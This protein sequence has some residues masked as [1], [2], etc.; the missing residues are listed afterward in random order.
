MKAGYAEPSP[1]SRQKARIS[2]ETQFEGF[3]TARLRVRPWPTETAPA[4]AAELA[5]LLTPPV[6]A[7]LPETMQLS[8][9]PGAASDW[10]AAR[11]AESTLCA[12][13]GR[14]SGAL[15]GLLILAEDPA[16][17]TPPTLHLGYLLGEDH[18]GRGYATEL[19]CGLVETLRPAAPLRLIGGVGAGNPASARV[20]RKAG[21]RPAAEQ[22]APDTEVFTMLL[23]GP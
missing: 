13:Q 22:A 23:P 4:A 17:D 12:I 1:G 15:L 20:L 6:L 5:R 7:H 16:P 21:F 2:M 11:R 14:D 8:A 9:G 18:W 3:E 10:I 19:V